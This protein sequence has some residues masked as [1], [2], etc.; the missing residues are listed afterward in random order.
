MILT[1]RAKASF[2]DFF[3]ENYNDNQDCYLNL[4]YGMSIVDGFYSMPL[5]MQYGAYLEWFDS[6]NLNI[7]ILR[8]PNRTFTFRINNTDPGKKEFSTREQVIA[9]ALQTGNSMYNEL[10]RVLN[11]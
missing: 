11:A 1:D 6:Q 3:I 4:G 10:A 2:E 8:T 7:E 9:S 5:C